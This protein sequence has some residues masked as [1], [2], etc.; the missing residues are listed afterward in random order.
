LQ[1][2]KALQWFKFPEII[3]LLERH[4][5]GECKC[6]S[7]AAYQ[8]ILQHFWN[9]WSAQVNFAF[10]HLDASQICSRPSIVWSGCVAHQS[11]LQ[12]LLGQ[13]RSSPSEAFSELKS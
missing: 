12:A 6:H 13:V 1:P 10:D 11:E 3:R 5:S 7:Q 8:V 9:S 4:N 2:G